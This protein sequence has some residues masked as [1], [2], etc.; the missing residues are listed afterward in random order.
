MSEKQANYTQN[1]SFSDASTEDRAN[2]LDEFN[3]KKPEQYLFS[4][5]EKI[6]RHIR[7]TEHKICKI[8]TQTHQVYSDFFCEH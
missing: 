7:L 5:Q 3:S 6:I 2:F 1:P 8:H 4:S